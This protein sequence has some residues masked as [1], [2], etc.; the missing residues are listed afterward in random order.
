MYFFSISLVV[1][2]NFWQLEVDLQLQK[3]KIPFLKW[4]FMEPL[5]APTAL[6]AWQNT[7]LHYFFCENQD[8][9]EQI[10]IFIFF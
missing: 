4:R 3:S 10:I 5:N 1:L 6:E 8:Y 2:G 7:I 9:V